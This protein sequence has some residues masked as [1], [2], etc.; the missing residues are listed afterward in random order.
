MSPPLKSGFVL[1][2]FGGVYEERSDAQGI[3]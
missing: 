1:L 3:F 2:G